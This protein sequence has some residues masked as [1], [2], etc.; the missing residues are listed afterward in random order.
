MIVKVVEASFSGIPY[1]VVG[2]ERS[3]QNADIPSEALLESDNSILIFRSNTASGANI[4]FYGKEAG[5]CN[6]VARLGENGPIMATTQICILDS[7][8]HKADG[9]Y[10]VIDV[11]NDGTKL[12]EGKIILSEVPVDLNIRLAIYTTGTTFLDGTL[13]KTLTAADF[14]ENGVCRYQM[15][16][17]DGSP[18]STCHG[19][20]FYQGSTF[21]FSYKN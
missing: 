9:Y 12:I 19:I 16:K 6:I 14:D 17:T 5:R 18:T 11:F 20:S 8:T 10:K 15:L 3:W 7:S 21:L 1:S 2:I 13:V 4:S